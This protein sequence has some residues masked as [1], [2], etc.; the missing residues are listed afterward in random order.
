MNQII[1][2]TWQ[3]QRRMTPIAYGAALKQLGLNTASAGRYLGVST[4]T[5]HRYLKGEREIPEASAMLLRGLIALK[6]A[7]VVPSWEADRNK[8]W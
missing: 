3:H 2:T 8:H 7:P 5:S 4:R 6:I 1:T